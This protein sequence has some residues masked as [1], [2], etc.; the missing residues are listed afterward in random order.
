MP[1]VAVTTKPA[2]ANA[3]IVAKPG[4][5]LRSAQPNKFSPSSLQP[6]GQDFELLTIKVPAGWSF[7]EV[8]QPITWSNVAAVVAKDALNTRRD[9]IGSLI[10]VCAEDGAFGAFLRI[11]SIVID[12]MGNANGLRVKPIMKW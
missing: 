11:E 10:Y 12:N 3:T 1:D 8:L 6:L 4:Q 5:T 9:K 2:K 7:E